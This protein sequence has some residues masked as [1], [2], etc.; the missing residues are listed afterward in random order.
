MNKKSRNGFSAFLAENKT[1]ILLIVLPVLTFMLGL[2]APSPFRLHIGRNVISDS[3]ERELVDTTN[4]KFPDGSVYEGT[5]VA[6]TKDR[7][8]FGRLTMKDGT[9]Y[10]GNWK[11]NGLPYG[12]RIGKSSVYTG[13]FDKDFNNEGFG[14][15]HYSAEYIAGKKKQGKNDYE[16]VESYIGNWKKNSKH[17]I[18]RS[19]NVD[20]SMDFGIYADGILQRSRGANYRIGGSVYGID[21]SHHQPDIDWDKLALYCDKDGNV[22]HGNPE[23][24]EYMQPV[25]FVYIKATEGATV[26]DNTFS[27]RMI[28]AER[29]GIVRGAY[30]FFRLGSSVEEQ[31]K[32][33][34]DVVTWHPGDMPPALD[35]E[36]VSEIEKYGAPK[37]QAMALEWLER[38]EEQLR[39]RPII[40]T[41]ESIRNKYLNDSRFKKYDF[42]IARYSE[43]GP[44]NFDWH[45]WQRTERGVIS[46]Y[47]RG[48]IDINL[49]KGDYMAFNK[50]LNN[51]IATPQASMNENSE[52]HRIAAKDRLKK[53]QAVNV[54]LR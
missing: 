41:R 14:I 46:G 36:V 7:H 33:F 8:G 48:Q 32:N 54:P 50:F 2:I 27:V 43:N 34:T 9:V 21:V 5:I 4:M 37:L 23:S 44:E 29:H 26:Q 11:E 39:V 28:E 53:G 6:K 25:F 42:W 10:E 38:I 17:G 45:I 47:D 15:I 40:Y 18:G 49:F 13:K 52:A 22:Y 31:V 12:K 16:I 24:R 20:G 19:V 1:A 51:M 3:D 35:I 30:H